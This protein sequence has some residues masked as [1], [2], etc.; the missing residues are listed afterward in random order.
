[1]LAARDWAIANGSHHHLRIV[2]CG[3]DTITMPADWRVRP[4]KFAGGR[5][6]APG[7]ARPRERSAAQMRGAAPALLPWYGAGGFTGLW[8]RR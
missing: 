5:R 7:E 1:M 6:V 2:L 4:V 8:Q 3:Y